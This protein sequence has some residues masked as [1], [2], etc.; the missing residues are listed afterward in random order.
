MDAVPDVAGTPNVVQIRVM[1]RKLLAD[2]FKL[3]F[4][5]ETRD[6]NAFVLSVAKGGAT[7]KETELKGPLPGLGFQP[8]PGGLG[9]I[10]HNGTMGD[11]AGFMQIVLLDR[12]VVDR[13]ALTGHYDLLVKFTPDDSQFNGHP[14]SL[15]RND[16]VEALPGLF[17]AM[18]QQAG[19]KLEPQ[20]TAVDVIAVDH[21]EKPSAN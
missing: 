12:P 16:A 21:V 9:M 19:L 10:V 20:K 15:P 8:V 3:K 6:M 11:L 4:H 17:E 14:P 2:R 1:I 5:K 7:L 13:T 18:Q